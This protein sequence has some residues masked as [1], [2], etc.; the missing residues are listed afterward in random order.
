MNG[1]ASAARTKETRLPRI[2]SSFKALASDSKLV[3]ANLWWGSKYLELNAC[4][5][6]QVESWVDAAR[7]NMIFPPTVDAKVSSGFTLYFKA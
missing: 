7:K 2:D 6:D 3:R 5:S 4:L 1:Q